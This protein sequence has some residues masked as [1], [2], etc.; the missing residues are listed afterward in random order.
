MSIVS[1]NQTGA[2]LFVGPGSITRRP[3]SVAV[4]R[5]SVVILLMTTGGI[6]GCAISYQDSAGAKHIIGMADVA[7][8]S[9]DNDNTIAG[10][11]VVVSTIG[12]LA[13]RNA[14]GSTFAFGYAKEATAAIKND[15]FVLGNPEQV[16]DTILSG[17]KQ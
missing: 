15:S 13:S 16:V 14:Q 12:V 11:V 3:M 1:G 7:V 10:D 2:T 4:Y 6:A 9:V 8:A 17:G 5:I